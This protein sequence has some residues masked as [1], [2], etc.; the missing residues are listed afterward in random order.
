MQKG[1]KILFLNR[2]FAKKIW[3][4]NDGEIKQNKK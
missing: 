2:Y 1:R 3:N 4:E